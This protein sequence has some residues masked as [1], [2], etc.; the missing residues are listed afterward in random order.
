MVLPITLI[1]SVVF[2]GARVAPSAELPAHSL[3]YIGAVVR[4]SFALA[5]SQL[6]IRI[7]ASIPGNK[8]FK[9]FA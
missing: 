2:F 4:H 9:A 7:R 5:K 1:L 6:T 8:L 3:T